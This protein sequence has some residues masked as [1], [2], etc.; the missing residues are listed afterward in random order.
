MRLMTRESTSPPRWS[1]GFKLMNMRPRLLPPLPRPV[2]PIDEPTCST[3]GSAQDDVERLRLQLE[4]RLERD[5]GG[6]LGRSHDQ[7]GVVL[8]EHAL[9][10]LHVEVNGEHDDAEKR[11][12]RHR[13]IAQ[14]DAQRARIRRNHPVERPFDD[15]VEAARACLPCAASGSARRSSA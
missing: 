15:A 11:E 14:R 1:S 10:D 6:G 2:P 5:V 12:Q 3:A 7:A 4:H 9:G 8:G 13:L